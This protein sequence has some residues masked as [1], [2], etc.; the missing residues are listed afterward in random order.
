MDRGQGTGALDELDELVVVALNP[1][2]AERAS[3]GRPKCEGL[4][5]RVHVEDGAPADAES[6]RLVGR[7]E[8]GAPADRR[9]RG[10]KKSDRTGPD[11]LGPKRFGSVRTGSVGPVSKSR[12]FQPYPSTQDRHK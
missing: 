3:Q 6:R 7:R 1:L 8:G 10:K 2:R 12:R 9:S 4:A 5:D 11:R